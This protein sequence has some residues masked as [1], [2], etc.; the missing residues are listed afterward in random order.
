M[1]TDRALN[2][3]L[4]EEEKVRTLSRSTAQI[5]FRGESRL[6][7]NANSQAVIQRM[8]VDPLTSAWLGAS[9]RISMGRADGKPR[10][11]SQQPPER[12]AKAQLKRR[13]TRAS[14]PARQSY[15]L[16]SAAVSLWHDIGLYSS[17]LS[18]ARASAEPPP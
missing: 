14:E 3:I 6:R 4:I 17:R 16:R 10:A 5:T 8:R 12:M 9:P 7:L 1:W 2:D 18:H 11:G 15:L 13:S